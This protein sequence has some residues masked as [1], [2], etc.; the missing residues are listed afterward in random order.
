[1]KFK[2]G[3]IIL[4]KG[5]SWMAR[6]IQWGTNSEYSHVSVIVSPEMSLFIEATN[7]I[8]RASDI[9]KLRVKYDVYRIKDKHKYNLD[10]VISFLVDKLGENYDFSGVIYLGFLKLFNLKGKAN[11]FQKD[12]D[13]FCSELVAMAFRVGSLDIIPEI[14]IGS[15]ASPGDISESTVLKH[16]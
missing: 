11:K 6:I 4:H 7:G 8:V 12:K 15:V 1:M 2:A 13:F 16:I 5:T 3:D 14:K 9:R 10:K